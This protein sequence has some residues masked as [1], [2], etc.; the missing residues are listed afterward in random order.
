MFFYP[1]RGSVSSTQLPRA[2]HTIAGVRPQQYCLPA[3]ADL[4]LCAPHD[5][6]HTELARRKIKQQPIQGW[7]TGRQ[8]H[9]RNSASTHTQS[10]EMASRQRQR[11]CDP[12]REWLEL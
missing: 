4:G 2:F 7:E 1:E 11:G 8:S 5:V 10:S 3:S 6:A 12:C 9:D